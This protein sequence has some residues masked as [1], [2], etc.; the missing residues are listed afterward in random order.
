MSANAEYLGGH[1][2]PFGVA[3]T[4]GWRRS[5]TLL[6]VLSG[7]RELAIDLDELAVYNF[8]GQ[9]KIWC[10]PMLSQNLRFRN[11]GSGLGVVI[12]Y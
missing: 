4:K 12:S 9:K 6:C 2:L 7:L 11:G 8:Q 5:T 10:D 3:Y 1:L